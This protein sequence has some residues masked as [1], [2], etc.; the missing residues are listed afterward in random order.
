M[1][2]REIFF[3]GAVDYSNFGGTLTLNPRAGYWCR[4]AG[5]S[6]PV[7]QLVDARTLFVGPQCLLRNA[8]A[9]ATPVKDASGATLGTLAA[10]DAAEL[11]LFDISTAAGGWRYRPRTVT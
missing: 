6:T 7:V 11:Y 10:G 8:G 3:R 4:L 2:T 1:M 5:I 9:N